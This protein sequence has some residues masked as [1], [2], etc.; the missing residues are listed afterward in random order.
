MND[1]CNTTRY[2]PVFGYRSLQADFEWPTAAMLAEMSPDVRLQSIKFSATDLYT[3]LSH[4]QVTLTDGSQSPYFGADL[5]FGSDTE[6]D[7]DSYGYKG[8]VQADKLV[9]DFKVWR[10]DGDHY[11]YDEDA[12]DL[13]DWS[14]KHDNVS[15][16]EFDS[17]TPIREVEATERSPYITSLRFYDKNRVEVYEY[18]AWEFG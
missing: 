10:Y 3:P 13:I 8:Q 11:S 14:P 4:A 7:Y 1:K 12:T 5:L 9:E 17:E 6:I 16:F 18:Q 15:T 2:L